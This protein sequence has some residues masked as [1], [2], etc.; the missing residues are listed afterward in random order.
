[1]SS[2]IL[3]AHACLYQWTIVLQ[4]PRA[5]K[6]SVDVPPDVD[7]S[8]VV[9]ELTPGDPTI[10]LGR[11]GR[12]LPFLA[13]AP[14]APRTG[15]A[16]SVGGRQLSLTFTK[17]APGTWPQ[18]IA[19]PIPES[20]FVIDPNSA[21]ALAA[22]ALSDAESA[23]PGAAAQRGARFLMSAV[24][25]NFP[26][27]LVWHATDLSFSGTPERAVP[28]LGIASEYGCPEADGLLGTLALR[29]GDFAEAIAR[30]RK[31]ADAGDLSAE[32]CLGEIYSPFEGGASGFEDPQKAFEIFTDILQ[33]NPDH[34]L[35]QYNLAQLYK[36]GAGVERDA[37]RARELCA[38]AKAAGVEVPDTD[39]EEEAPGR[40]GRVAAAAVAAAGAIAGVT[41]IGMFLTH[42]RH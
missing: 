13:G 11:V 25:A 17:A 38:R 37:A 14:T 40:W 30:F 15:V 16:R 24:A 20:D 6:I 1:M 12:E 26:P 22:R 39:F 19:G 36:N 42:R 29:R 34:G 8:S 31:A 41:A 5:F 33:K 18:F 27:A 32:N 35:A 21:L 7:P 28:V 9:V 2:A 10:V 4:T 23:D 3:P